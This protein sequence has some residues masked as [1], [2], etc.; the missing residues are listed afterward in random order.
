M[1]DLIEKLFM[2]IKP[3]DI[4]ISMD[5]KVF[6]YYDKDRDELLTIIGTLSAENHSLTQRLVGLDIWLKEVIGEYYIENVKP[7]QEKLEKKDDVE[8]LELNRTYG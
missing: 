6:D 7:E 4:A 1:C 3:E 8:E 2:N 5:E